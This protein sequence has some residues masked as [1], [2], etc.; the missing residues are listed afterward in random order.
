M[1]NLRQD[2]GNA[3]FDPSGILEDISVRLQRFGKR[4]FA[5]YHGEIYLLG[6]QLNEG[7]KL[8][9]GVIILAPISLMAIAGAFITMALRNGV[10]LEVALFSSAAICI[11]SLGV[12]VFYRHLKL[13]SLLRESESSKQSLEDKFDNAKDRLLE[14]LSI[15]KKEALKNVRIYNPIIAVRE[16]PEKWVLGSFAAG[17]CLAVF[18]TN[19]E[20][21]ELQK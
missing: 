1:S 15:T 20:Q 12:F 13:K 9:S 7:T 4:A 5:V 2:E 14:S 11:V 21:K 6:R 3:F 8:A 19:N 16:S 18:F 10:S 17:I